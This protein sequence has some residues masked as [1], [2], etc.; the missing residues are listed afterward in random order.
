MLP[1][2]QGGAE[3][4]C[5]WF[6]DGCL[7]LHCLLMSCVKPKSTYSFWKKSE[8]F[9]F[10]SG[11]FGVAKYAAHWV[12]WVLDQPWPSPCTWA[13]NTCLLLTKTTPSVS[14]E[15]QLYSLENLL[16][17]SE[18]AGFC[19]QCSSTAVQKEAEGHS[20]QWPS[21]SS[22]LVV[23]ILSITNTLTQCF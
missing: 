5:D 21:G 2:R 3:V 7:F 20:G 18:E 1:S 15:Q 14:I 4:E 6:T 13:F 16:L 23:E 8:K 17:P 10:W 12:E 22:W 19:Y 11:S 9:L